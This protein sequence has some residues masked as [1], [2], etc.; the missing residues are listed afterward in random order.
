MLDIEVLRVVEDCHVIAVC[1][2]KSR[3]L[4]VNFWRRQSAADGSW[5]DLSHGE[6]YPTGFS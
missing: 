4:V 1:R 5:S 3:I 2:S 6:G